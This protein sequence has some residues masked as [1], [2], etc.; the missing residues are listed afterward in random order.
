MIDM[1]SVLYVLLIQTVCLGV[2]FFSSSKNSSQEYQGV[3]PLRFGVLIVGGALPITL[4]GANIIERDGLA[5]LLALVG[6]IYFLVIK[7]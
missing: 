4:L 3:N 5:V 6:F 7:K 2:L 1:M